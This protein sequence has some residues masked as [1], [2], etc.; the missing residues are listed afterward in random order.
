VTRIKFVVLACGMVAGGAVVAGQQAARDR[1]AAAAAV[2]APRR[3]VAPIVEPADEPG[4]DDPDVR[5]AMDRLQLEMLETEVAKLRTEVNRALDE[6]VG[7]EIGFRRGLG[8]QGYNAEGVAHAQE[9]LDQARRVY[10]KKVRELASLRRRIGSG[11]GPN[12]PGGELPDPFDPL[13][14]R[15]ADPTEPAEPRA[16]TAAV[17]SI[18]ID[19]VFRRY[20]KVVQSQERLQAMRTD[21]TERLAKL[22]DDAKAIRAKMQ[23]LTPET[24]EYAALEDRL[25][26]VK[27][28]IERH[29]ERSQRELE[30]G[31]SRDMAGIFEDVRDAVAA[32]AKARGLDYVIKA[33]VKPE[34]PA[35]A[36][37]NQVLAAVNR[38]VLYA[39]PRNDITEEVIRELNRRAADKGRR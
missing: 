24:T 13:E 22:E 8:G 19:A 7:C 35:D 36:D 34:L 3:A 14:M 23:R 10:R 20:I 38:S 17:G 30:R 26:A 4:N 6:K 16:S 39:N 21:A 29:R 1:A 11:G 9:V 32:V 27:G 31:Q 37:P 5:R 18:D 2:P 33:E 28:D 25:A 15:P 12:R